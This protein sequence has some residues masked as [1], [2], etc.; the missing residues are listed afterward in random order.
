M[1][2]DDFLF[3]IETQTIREFTYKNEIYR[4]SFDKNPAGNNI[5]KFGRL[6]E[7]KSY[8]S[9]GELLNNAK[10]QNHFFKDMLDIF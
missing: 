2:K 7:E 9:A 3:L 1:T 4:L 6:Y 10:I 5:I 8:D